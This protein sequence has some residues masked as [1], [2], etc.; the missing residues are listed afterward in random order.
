MLGLVG[1]FIGVNWALTLYIVNIILVFV[2]GEIA[3]N[4]L[5]GEPTALIME[6]SDYRIPHLRTVLKQTWF[7]LEEYIKIASP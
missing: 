1:R 6:M 2:L 5:P 4:L 3:F 7:R